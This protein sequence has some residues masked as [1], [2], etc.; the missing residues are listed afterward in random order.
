MRSCGWRSRGLGVGL[1]ACGQTGDQRVD[2]ASIDFFGE[3]RAV[4]FDQPDAEDIQ[5]K[6]HPARALTGCFLKAVIQLD[7]IALA[8][9]FG[10]DHQIFVFLACAQG[11]DHHHLIADL[12]ERTRIGAHQQDLE[13]VL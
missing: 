12:A 2:A 3:L 5:V 11:L 13:F 9:H 4:V 7:R 6:N 8:A 10:V 1:V